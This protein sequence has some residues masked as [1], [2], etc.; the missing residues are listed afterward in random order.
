M[1][2]PWDYTHLGNGVIYSESNPHEEERGGWFFHLF[3]LYKHKNKERKRKERKESDSEKPILAPKL[4]IRGK[5][6]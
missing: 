3:S 6:G 5:Y 4:R 1:I 2:I